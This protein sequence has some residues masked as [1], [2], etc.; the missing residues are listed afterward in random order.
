M[1][2]SL[3]IRTPIIALCFSSLNENLTQKADK[4]VC[5]S[6]EYDTGNVWVDG[7]HIYRRDILIKNL[8]VT[9]SAKLVIDSALTNS[10]I[11]VLISINGSAKHSS[12]NDNVIV[13][14]VAGEMYSPSTAYQINVDIRSGGATLTYQWGSVSREVLDYVAVSVEYTKA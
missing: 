7:K 6:T 4:I 9:N 11:D 5:S 2:G 14:I 13:P 1:L 12:V 3:G 8:S 10:Y